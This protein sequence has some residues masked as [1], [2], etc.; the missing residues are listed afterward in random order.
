MRI[1]HTEIID[2]VFEEDVDTYCVRCLYKKWIED[3]KSYAVPD[4][5]GKAFD[6]YMRE[7][8]ISRELEL[9]GLSSR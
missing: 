6:D 9:L 5:N 4:R 2:D 7:I 1:I 8:D 3:G